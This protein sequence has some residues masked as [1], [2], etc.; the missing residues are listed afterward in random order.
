MT[1]FQKG[2]WVKRKGYSHDGYTV[3]GYNCAGSVIVLPIGKENHFKNY[4]I[5]IEQQLMLK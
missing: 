2:D 1:K 4:D 5:F 3:I